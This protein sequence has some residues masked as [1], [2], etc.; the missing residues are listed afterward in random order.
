MK[1]D[2][3]RVFDESYQAAR[4]LTVIE[5]GLAI[6][7]LPK[8]SSFTLEQLLDS[9]FFPKSQFHALAWM[10]NHRKQA[11]DKAIALLLSSG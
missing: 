2:F 1:P 7:T 4:R 3:D 9:D 5:T 11:I 10:N 6:A 8:Q